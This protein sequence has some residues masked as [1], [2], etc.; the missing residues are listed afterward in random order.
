MENENLIIDL[1]T[2]VC[3]AMRIIDKSDLKILFVADGKHLIG[4]LTDGDIRRFLFNGGTLNDQ[5]EK[6]ANHQP[7]TARSLKHASELYNRLYYIAIPGA[8][9]ALLFPN[10]T[11]TPVLNFFH[12][13]SF[14]IHILLV[15][16]PLLLVTTDQVE[17]DLKAALKGVG[18][19]V[20][21]AIPVYG[22]N[23][24]WDTN[25]MFLMESDSGNPLELFQQLL[26]SHLWG[27]PILL[28]VVILVMYLPVYIFKHR[29]NRVK[30]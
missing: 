13:H 4:S 23:L 21:I 27:F 1:Q 28:P 25:F 11:E 9:L 19:L 17:T 8:A 7:R 6:A 2:S 24:L 15:L 26:G 10:W 16:Y 30:V 22:L 14:T 12:I 3:D 18:L 5:A 29:K 20:A